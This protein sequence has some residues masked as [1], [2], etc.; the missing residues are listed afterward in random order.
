MFFIIFLVFV[1]VCL[2][3]VY[4]NSFLKKEGMEI[5]NE[6]CEDEENPKKSTSTG[7]DNDY[8][9][10]TLFL[11][12]ESGGFKVKDFGG[13]PPINIIKESFNTIAVIAN[14]A[15]GDEG[16]KNQ[17]NDPDLLKLKQ[18][19]G[20]PLVHWMAYYF[21]Y[22]STLFCDC[23]IKGCKLKGT[24]QDCEK[25]KQALL[26][27]I[28]KD[29]QSYN[30]TG[31]LF[32]DEVGDPSCIVEAM[33]SIKSVYPSMQ[34]GWTKSLG[35]AKESSPSNLGTLDWDI[36]LGQA[37]TDSTTN[38]YKES[39]NFAD[40]FW[41]MIIKTKYDPSTSSTRGV[42]MVCGSGN[43][44]EI[45]GCIDERM[46]GAQIGDILQ[47]RPPKSS[48]KWRNF[49]IWYGTYSNPSNCN[50]KGQCCT[51]D[52]SKN[53]DCESSCCNEWVMK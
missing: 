43:C 4:N 2:G 34:L 19:S 47:K 10:G 45:D 40:D 26:T 25:C 46:T 53:S 51:V 24:P 5:N 50:N 36:C 49:G 31:I 33:E 48:F 20:L 39:C 7:N 44:Q 16:I 35:N 15:S 41:D 52:N 38:L 12:P 3:L 42:P 13:F 1:I 32:D 30:L 29:V 6:D 18:E 21:G 37:Y 27:Q 9:K 8:Q 28:H 23:N 17:F 11:Y 22:D 14:H